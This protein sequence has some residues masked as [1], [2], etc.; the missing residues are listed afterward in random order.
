MNTNDSK[1]FLE[2]GY[3]IY[4]IEEKDNL[5]ILKNTIKKFHQ[6]RKLIFIS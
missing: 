1:S 6:Y 3:L 4:K 2:K 5:E